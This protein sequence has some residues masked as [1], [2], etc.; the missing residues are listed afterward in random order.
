MI[1]TEIPDGFA[2][3]C[4]KAARAQGVPGK[5]HSYEPG[6]ES[7]RVQLGFEQEGGLVLVSP[8]LTHMVAQLERLAGVDTPGGRKVDGGRSASTPDEGTC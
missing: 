8:S 1:P 6:N 5:V 2:D 4:G 7:L 3:L